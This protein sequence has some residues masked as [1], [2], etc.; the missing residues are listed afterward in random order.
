MVNI[1]YFAWGAELSDDYNE[2]T[3]ITGWR[4]ALGDLGNVSALQVPI[5]SGELFGYGGMPAEGIVIVGFM[6]MVLL[7]VL[8]ALAVWGVPERTVKRN[9]Q[10]NLWQAAK[11]M[12]KN[13]SFLLL[14]VSFLLLS[15]GMAWMS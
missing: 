15:A 9:I 14:F 5:I 10:P 6:V 13:G 11:K 7:P 4:Q 12:F 3:R 2:R 1:P 8:A